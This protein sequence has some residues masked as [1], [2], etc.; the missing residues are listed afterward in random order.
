MTTTTLDRT[1]DRRSPAVRWLAAMLEQA[2]VR[3]VNNPEF[4]E[5]IAE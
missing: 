5:H 1:P 2:R 3:E 4:A